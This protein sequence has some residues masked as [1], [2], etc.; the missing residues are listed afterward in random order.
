MQTNLVVGV[1]CQVSC[2]TMKAFCL[3]QT[4]EVAR[5][6]STVTHMLD[7]VAP[8]ML[9]EA[10]AVTPASATTIVETSPASARASIAD[11]VQQS[12]QGN[13][14]CCFMQSALT[15]LT[16]KFCNI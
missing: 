16:V 6:V 15:I 12:I 7:E 11:S 5:N 4:P 3:L 9:A 1:N 10:D 13:T 2:K 14:C 8:G